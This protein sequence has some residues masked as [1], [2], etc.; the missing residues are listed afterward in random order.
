MVQSNFID[1]V[2]HH[3][4][5]TIHDNTITNSELITDMAASFTEFGLG[6]VSASEINVDPATGVG[7][8]ISLSDT[9]GKCEPEFNR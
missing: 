4:A 6:Y 3:N 1:N 2:P 5:I 9:K 8:I 7:Y